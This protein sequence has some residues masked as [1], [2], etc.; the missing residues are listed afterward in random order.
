MADINW[1][2]SIALN[3]HSDNMIVNHKGCTD[4]KYSEQYYL[5]GLGYITGFEDEM[6]ENKNLNKCL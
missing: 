2:I 6:L 1:K 5:G 4:R 3:W